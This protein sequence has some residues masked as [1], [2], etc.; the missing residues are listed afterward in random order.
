MMLRGERTGCQVW[1]FL[2]LFHTPIYTEKYGY[3]IAKTACRK[4]QHARIELLFIM[5]ILIRCKPAVIDK[6]NSP[7]N[8][9]TQYTLENILAMKSVYAIRIYELLQSKIMSRVLPKDGV[10]ITIPIKELKECCDCMDKYAEFSNFRMKVLDKAK[11]EINRVTMFRID[12]SYV[13]KGRSVA[14]IEFHVNMRY[15]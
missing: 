8:N 9:Y 6:F 14:G 2:F 10:N 1:F 11:S 15:H 3:T 5:K 4:K 13:K 12:Y 7:A